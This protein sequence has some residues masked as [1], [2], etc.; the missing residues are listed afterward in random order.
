M[1]MFVRLQQAQRY[2]VDVADRNRREPF[3]V[4]AGSSSIERLFVAAMGAMTYANQSAIHVNSIY[5]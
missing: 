3:P 1:A 2:S 4:R 5:F